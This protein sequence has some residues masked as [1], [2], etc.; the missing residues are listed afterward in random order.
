[1]SVVMELR[2]LNDAEQKA[3]IDGLALLK[4]GADKG[5]SWVAEVLLE[6]DA[7]FV[8]GLFWTSKKEGV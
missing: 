4:N 8:R 3:I 2:R 1:M 6:D 5:N 7:E